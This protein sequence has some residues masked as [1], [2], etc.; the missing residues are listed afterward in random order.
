MLAH[1]CVPKIVGVAALVI[2]SGPGLCQ[3]QVPGNAPK[4]PQVS[5]TPTIGRSISGPAIV[6]MTTTE[7]DLAAF[8]Q[9]NYRLLLWGWLGCRRP[10]VQQSLCANACY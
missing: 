4:L 10:R 8:A 6:D 3:E 7:T 1:W 2:L 9:L 5:V